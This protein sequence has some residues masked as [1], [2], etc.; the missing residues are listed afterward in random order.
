[1]ILLKATGRP[2]NAY[3]KRCKVEEIEHEILI[4][5]FEILMEADVRRNV[6]IRKTIADGMMVRDGHRFYVEVDNETMSLKQMKEKWIRYDGN[7]DYILLICR[8]KGRLRRLMRSA[9]RVKKLIFFSRFDWLRKTHV[10]HKW[11]DWYCKRAE[12]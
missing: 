10:K 8:T 5:E 4:T 7:E 2:E 1:M 6:P 9:E 11:I 3:G 12:I